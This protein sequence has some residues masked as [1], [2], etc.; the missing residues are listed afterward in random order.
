M[1]VRQTAEPA[2]RRLALPLQLDAAL[3]ERHYG[4]FER[5]LYTEVRNRYPEHYARFQ[6]KDP[7]YDFESGESLRTF[8]ERS[9][10]IV[11]TIAARHPGEQ[12]LVFTHGGVLEMVYR[13]ARSV[14]LESPRDFGIPNCGVNWVEITTR[15]WDVQCWA[16]IEHLSARDSTDDGGR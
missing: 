7:D 9:L 16:D 13:F 14:G 3:R 1:R 10:N 8:N 12:V 2:A 11:K 4:I 5:L 15:G 6:R